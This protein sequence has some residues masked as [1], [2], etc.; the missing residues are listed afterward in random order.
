MGKIALAGSAL[1]L[2]QL[3]ACPA[4]AQTY[5]CTN[6]LLTG[7][8]WNK[9]AK[10]WLAREMKGGVQLVLKKNVEKSGPPG[11]GWIVT[12]P[13]KLGVLYACPDALAY[14]DSL[15]C[16]SSEGD[17]RINLKTLRFMEANYSTW[18]DDG[19]TD[20][21]PTLALGQCARL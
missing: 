1:V 18:I 13:G 4:V 3:A 19:T 10:K 11:T 14:G 21:T 20:F 8:V 5:L 12:R 7:F 6:S 16:N 9:P 15:I 2:W 17:F